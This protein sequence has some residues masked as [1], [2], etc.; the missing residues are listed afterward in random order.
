MILV[1]ILNSIFKVYWMQLAP[2]HY[3]Q[4]H[5]SCI[6]LRFIALLTL[7]SVKHNALFYHKILSYSFLILKTDGPGSS[8]CWDPS[9][10]KLTSV[11]NSIN[12]NTTCTFQ[13][14]VIV[15]K[16]FGRKASNEIIVAFIRCFTE[17]GRSLTQLCEV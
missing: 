13:I 11:T 14:D 3:N 15:Q 9:T 2:G 6:L 16:S 10:L 8:W 1:D 5:I 4:C 12:F 7:S 17:R